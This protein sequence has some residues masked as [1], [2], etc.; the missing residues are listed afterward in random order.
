M[1]QLKGVCSVLFWWLTGGIVESNKHLKK[2]IMNLTQDRGETQRENV[3]VI[4]LNF[5][6]TNLNFTLRDC[7]LDVRTLR[8]HVI[9]WIYDPIFALRYTKYFTC[10]KVQINDKESYKIME[11]MVE[12]PLQR[13]QRPFGYIGI[14]FLVF[15]IFIFHFGFS[16]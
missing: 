16:H 12:M 15:F 14:Q 4:E 2:R 8:W 9:Y 6:I 1:I 13:S 3:L 5:S 7:G 10:S 11:E